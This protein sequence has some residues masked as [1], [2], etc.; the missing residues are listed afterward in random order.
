MKKLLDTIEMVIEMISR[1]LIGGIV[2]IIF[3]AVVMRY[4]FHRPPAWSEELSRFIFIWMI[5][6]SAVLV[7]REQS[8]IQMTFLV[9]LLPERLRF[10]LSNFIRLLMIAFCWVMIQQGL[11]IY[12]IVAEASSPSFGISM[13]WLYL[14]IPVSGML[15]GLYVLEWMVKSIIARG[16]GTSSRE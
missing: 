15:M 4:V 5:M 7:T 14:A 12:P 8:H 10:F 3:Y 1:I 13:G 2:A 6:L 16:R 9:D 11:K